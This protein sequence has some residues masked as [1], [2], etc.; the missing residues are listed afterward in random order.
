MTQEFSHTRP[1]LELK[2][3]T[4]AQEIWREGVSFNGSSDKELNRVAF[5][6]IEVAQKIGPRVC[7]LPG[8]EGT[9]GFMIG[10][11]KNEPNSPVLTV[12]I[13]KIEIEDP[14]YWPDGK[15]GKY[16]EFIDKKAEAIQTNP[17]FISSGENSKLPDK[18]KVKSSKGVEIPDGAL[19]FGEHDEYIIATSGFKN[20]K[21]D[22]AVSLCLGVGAGLKR[23]SQAAQMAQDPRV[24]CKKEF[25][26]SGVQD[27]LIDEA[28]H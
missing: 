17:G 12:Q 15:R 26:A 2:N 8:N 5:K 27:I 19:V 3:R 13:G 6:A 20:A 18:W 21:M 10:I 22:A 16:P 25:L 14:L 1:E 11:T 23:M 28:V 4:Q 9:Q 24:G 7:K